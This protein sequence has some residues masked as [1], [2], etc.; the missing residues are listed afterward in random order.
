MF[1]YRMKIGTCKQLP[2]NGRSGISLAIIPLYWKIFSTIS[3]DNAIEDRVVGGTPSPLFAYC[4]T[5]AM[6]IM[7]LIC[8]LHFEKGAISN[9][10][11]FK[12]FFNYICFHFCYNIFFIP[13]DD[14]L[15][16]VHVLF[17]H[18]QH[19]GTRIFKFNF[20]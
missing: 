3:H 16:S 13:Q 20:I 11:M 8:L 12:I 5:N 6:N 2:S 18:Y 14:L 15:F 17:S 1:E 19:K 10:F 4:N 9:N 7:F